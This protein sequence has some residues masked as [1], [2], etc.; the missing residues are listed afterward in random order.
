MNE[1]SSTGLPG[2]TAQLLEFALDA[3]EAGKLAEAETAYLRVLETH[4][5]HA[6]VH[7]NLGNLLRQTGRFERAEACYRRALEL[8]QDSSAIHNNLG[9]LLEDLDRPA[10]AEATYRQALV[11][12]PDMAAARFNLGI[13]LLA[14]GRYTEGW[15]HYE[16]RTQAFEENGSLPFPRWQGESPG[17]KALLLLPEQ[18]YGDT[19]QFARYASL[20]KR[21]GVTRLSLI[22]NDAIKPLL[23][24]L[25]GIDD[26][27]TEPGGLR[28]HDYWDFLPSMPRRFGT[29]LETIPVTMPYLGALPERLE[30]WRGRLPA[31]GVRIGLAWKGSAEHWNDGHRSLPHFFAL[32]P[33]WSIPGVQFVSLQKGEGENEP[34]ECATRQP[35]VP[36][37]TSIRDFG[38]TAAIVAQLDLVIC[39]DTAIAHVAGALGVPCWVMLP[40]QGVDWRWLR[41]GTHS[42]WYPQTMRLFRQPEFGGWAELIQDVAASLA[43][44]VPRVEPARKPG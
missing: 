34:S 39:V 22:C 18:G 23:Q 29:T 37:G 10:E 28:R 36:L 30:T 2:D 11:L 1:R 44:W 24:T 33:L 40:G 3:H 26:L 27:I 41:Q 5:D 42:P 25:D 16:A 35:L 15:N 32:H 7:G 13:L 17:G 4:P 8:A 21:Q 38:D 6:L 19:I 20:L 9:G 43:G 12:E 14:L 31:S